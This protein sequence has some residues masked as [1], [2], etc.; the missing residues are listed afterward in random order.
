MKDSIKD[1]KFS[2]LND[3]IGVKRDFYTEEHTTY[4]PSS[5]EAKMILLQEKL[6]E[7][8]DAYLLDEPDRSLGNVYVNSVILPRLLELSNLNKIVVIVTHSAN[9]AVS[10]LLFVL[11]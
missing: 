6:I 7:T 1:T 3:L 2:S 11:S 8:A 4:E 5:G 10:A 9:L